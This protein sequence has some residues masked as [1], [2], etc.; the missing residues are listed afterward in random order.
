MKAQLDN[1]LM[2]SMLL[3]VDHEIQKQGQAFSNKSGLFYRDTDKV[4]GLYTYTCP[5]K[6]LCNDT[7]ISGAVVMSGVY[8]SG[9]YTP[10]GSG[11]LVS[12]NHYDGSVNFDHF[13]PE[14]A[15]ISG[16][17]GVKDFAVYLSDQPDY[18]V[19]MDTKFSSNP[20]YDQR[21]TGIAQSTK[22]FPAV[23]LVA[24]EQEARPL[25]FA[26]V[27]DNYM[28]VR[29]MIVCENA[30]QRLAVTNIL[31]N[32]KLRNL[33]IFNNIPFDFRG[34]MT[35]Q[36]YNWNDLTFTTESVPFIQSVK[37]TAIPSQN[38]YVDATR[39]F[40]MVDFDVSAWGSHQ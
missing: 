27:D 7:S 2:Q 29:A 28:R 33:P 32:L 17:F 25:A 11:G 22:V 37:G 38:S 39:Q 5:Y 15:R 31:K 36:N 1:K 18:T 13:L 24:K 21:A 4:S 26:G 35:G 6:Q 12:I 10:V 8:V 9:V 3:M 14:S 16:N 30:F 23:I 34:N 19:V 20:K 40:G